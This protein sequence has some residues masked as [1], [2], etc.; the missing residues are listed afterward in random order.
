MSDT[1]ERECGC[2]IT[3]HE[4]YMRYDPCPVH[5]LPA[6][7]PDMLRVERALKRR[8]EIHNA[9]NRAEVRR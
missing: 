1:I 8:V 3:I 2:K 7:R 5:Q 6:A 9:R 4:T